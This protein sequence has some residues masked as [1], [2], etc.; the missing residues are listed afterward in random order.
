MLDAKAISFGKLIALSRESALWSWQPQVRYYLLDLGAFPGDELAR[1]RSL[2]ALLFRL[3]QPLGACLGND[4]RNE[5]DPQRADFWDRFPRIAG[6]YVRERIAESRRCGSAA[7]GEHC[8]DRLLEPPGARRW[9][10]SHPGWRGLE[11]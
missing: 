6:L 1:R 8:S 9:S 4:R 10:Q 11:C 2:A 5:G 7:V 3:E